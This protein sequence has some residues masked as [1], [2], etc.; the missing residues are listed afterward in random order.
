MPME[1]LEAIDPQKVKD[2]EHIVQETEVNDSAEHKP[3]KSQEQLDDKLA[4]A[5][6]LDETWTDDASTLR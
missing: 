4:E 1:D 2:M 3:S 6:A 5:Q